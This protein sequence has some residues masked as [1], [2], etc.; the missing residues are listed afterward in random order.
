MTW[1]EYLQPYFPPASDLF[2][3]EFV[4][5]W[6]AQTWSP[7]DKDKIAAAKLHGQLLS[8]IAT[9]RLGYLDG[10]EQTA[11]ESIYTLFPE[12]RRI[13]DENAPC[14]HFE[15]IAWHVLN[16][17]VRPFT[18]KWH[19]ES[20][21]RTLESL[22]ATDEF[23]SELVA[24]QPLLQRFEDLLAYVAD[25]ERPAATPTRDPSSPEKRSLSDG[26]DS[27]GWTAPDHLLGIGNDQLGQKILAAE[28]QSI[29]AR[30]RHYGI[31]EKAHTIGLALSGGGIRSATFSL[32]ILVALARRAILPQIDYLSTV[33]GG[34]FVGSFL[35]VFL[36]STAD[37]QKEPRIGLRSSE[38][39]FLRQE[40][41]AEA[42]RHIRHHSKYLAS[43]SLWERTK[44]VSAQIYGMLVNFAGILFIAAILALVEF[45]VRDASVSRGIW[46]T[47]AMLSVAALLA[48]SF[49]SPLL[50]RRGLAAQR[51]ADSI[52]A[53]LF[54]ILLALVGWK[55][56]GY[57]H[58]VAWKWPIPKWSTLNHK[59]II[60]L[61]GAIPAIASAFS[62]FAGRKL[63]RASIFL[64]VLAAVATPLFLFALYLSIYRWLEG[65]AILMPLIA[66]PPRTLFMAAI[67][68]ALSL[69]YFVFLD[70]NFTSPHRYYRNKLAAAYLIQPAA[71]PT[72]TQ[73]FSEA[74]N[75]KL[76]EVRRET[77]APYH[78]LNAALN[79]P[80]ST[81]PGMQGRL[82]DFF[83]F[84]SAYC[85]SPL[86]GYKET[87]AW[88]DW[89]RHLNV[90]TAMAISGAA[91]APQMGLATRPSLR[92]WLALLNVRLGYWV[93]KPDHNARFGSAPGLWFL[94]R[95][96]LGWMNEK[97]TWINVSDGG[98]I[99][100]LGVYE[101]LRRRC[102]YIL[103]VDGEQDQRMTFAALTT[104]QRLAAIDLNTRIDINLDDLRL[105]EQGLS[106]SHFRFCRIH[107]PNNRYGYL[108]Y[109]KL[110]LTGNEGE[111]IRRYRSDDPAFPHDSTAN[112][113]F[114]ETQ[115][116]A[117]RSL[118]EHVGDKLFLRAIVGSLADSTNIDIEPWFAALAANL[119][120]PP[121]GDH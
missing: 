5:K 94:F 17:H 108:L 29:D 52:V 75:L 105:N 118:G 13:V 44:T 103:A 15:V 55:A 89:D 34:G 51:T 33:S 74:G 53:A 28:R 119:L 78:L 80:S 79:V 93:R 41:E 30:R 111:F 11:L 23:R 98:H 120:E 86:I 82:T 60:A 83:L 6:S 117:Y 96:M 45:F 76:S 48:A 50:L 9:Q 84:S 113:F 73:P 7:T 66:H 72:P 91:A 100:N 18:A 69:L 57:C 24:L 20:K 1:R 116:E 87:T 19:F 43:R 56:L 3:R 115:F 81:N 49:V 14:R 47:A 22:D 95:E 88:E 71:N 58:Q 12:C 102:R 67:I 46:T 10:V 59:T 4:Q 64:V 32:G 101:L 40:G 2:D 109:L 8:R 62:G 16:T 35:T 36:S 106:R 77:R 38:L 121:R 65:P 90:G 68:L 107:Y 85:G 104:L 110:S 21:R 63:P 39:P 92:F 97:S 70:I 42:L 112:Q 27:G 54:L 61:L 26:A 99:E 114:T 25:G 31:P 37:E